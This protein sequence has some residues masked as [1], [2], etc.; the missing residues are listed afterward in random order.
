ML[1]IIIISFVFC[2]VLERVIPGWKLPKVPTWPIRV[3]LIN[4]IQLIVVILA[5]YTCGFDETKELKLKEI[6]AF[7]N[8]LK[9]K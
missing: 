2:F 5:G 6:L 4:G 9:E 3:L 8:I 1:S 7:T